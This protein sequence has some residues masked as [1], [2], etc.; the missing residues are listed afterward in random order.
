M[1]YPPKEAGGKVTW[2]DRDATV[3]DRTSNELFLFFPYQKYPTLIF[4]TLD[5]DQKKSFREIL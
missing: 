5:Y 2:D 1:M 4:Y 3:F